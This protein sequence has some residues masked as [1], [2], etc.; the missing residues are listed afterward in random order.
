MFYARKITEDGWF[1]K[2]NLDADSISELGTS[3]HELSVWK[4]PDI[5]DSNNVDKVALALALTRS[6]VEE[7]YMVF[8]NTLDLEKSAR[9]IVAT[10]QQDG[11]TRYSRM[12][13]A[14][15]N[16]IVPTFWKQGYL[17]EYIHK[18]IEDE[19]NYRYYDAAKLKELVY[20]AIKSGELVKDEI[21]NDGSWK[22][23][24]TEMENLYGKI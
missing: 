16:F 18:L 13:K 24:V 14:H 22:R 19:Q 17:G 11:E 6:K 1:G 10:T 12:K 2:G 23:A 21:K 5:S 8:L 3:N 9:W 15:A 7:F 4:I 20:N